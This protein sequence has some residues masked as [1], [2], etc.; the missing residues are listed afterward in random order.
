[1]AFLDLE[2]RWK[3]E[4]GDMEVLVGSS[5][6]DIKLKDSFR[7]VSDLYTDGKNRGFY[8]DAVIC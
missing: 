7:I 6:N 8:A 1:M 5:S 4:A 3:V 2:M